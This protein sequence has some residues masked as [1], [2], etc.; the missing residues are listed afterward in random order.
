MASET[1]KFF[2]FNN[3]GLF[4]DHFLSKRLPAES[5]L[6]SSEKAAAQ[7]CFEKILA[8]YKKFTST[9][10]AQRG[11]KPREGNL[12]EISSWACPAV[13]GPLRCV[14]ARPW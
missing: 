6:W 10:K 9:Y 7:N 13:K 1:G 2:P 4:S 8:Q 3:V 11:A 5:P 12:P 14:S